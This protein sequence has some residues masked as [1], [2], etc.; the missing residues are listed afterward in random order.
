MCEDKTGQAA[1]DGLVANVQPP[2][3]VIYSMDFSM[4][5]DTPGYSTFIDTPTIQ[6][7][8]VERLSLLFND[9]DTSNIVIES[10]L[11]GSTVVTWHNRSLSTEKCP[12][13]VGALLRKVRLLISFLFLS[14]EFA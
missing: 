4:V 10:V 6:R 8:F 1:N 14:L 3:K 11:P 13:D 5:I 2:P 7:H 12:E 9:P